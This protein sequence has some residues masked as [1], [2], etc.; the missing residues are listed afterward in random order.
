ME[1]ER[2][3]HQFQPLR[4]LRGRAP[5]QA[6]PRNTTQESSKFF[7]GFCR[8]RCVGVWCANAPGTSRKSTSF[9]DQRHMRRGIAP[10]MQ[11]LLLLQLHKAVIPVRLARAPRK[12][13]STNVHR[14]RTAVGCGSHLLSVPRQHAD[15]GGLL[16]CRDHP[17]VATAAFDTP[18]DAASAVISV[19]ATAVFDTPVD[20]AT[21]THAAVTC[22]AVHAAAPR[23]AA[24]AATC[25]TAD[26]A[27]ASVTHAD[28]TDV[29]ATRRRAT[30]VYELVPRVTPWIHQST[31]PERGQYQWP[32]FLQKRPFCQG[33][34][35]DGGSGA[36]GTAGRGE[37]A[38]HRRVRRHRHGLRSVA[39]DAVA[40]PGA[41]TSVAVTVTR[42]VVTSHTPL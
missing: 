17:V 34:Q 24:C 42:A 35:C 21:V 41:A 37:A 3:R 25:A 31:S 38:A 39:A 36:G 18:V 6:G 23:V 32:I 40:P 33:L 29:C 11:L 1:P 8:G 10:L 12:A 4:A 5:R 28:V 20:T 16:H 19:A 7:I 22:A 13:G 14:Y 9:C 30:P 26:A 27:V 15:T 2:R